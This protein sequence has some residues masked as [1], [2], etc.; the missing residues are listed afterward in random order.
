MMKFFLILFVTLCDIAFCEE[1]KD[2][3]T[4][5]LDGKP[6]KL[7]SIKNREDSPMREQP[8]PPAKPPEEKPCSR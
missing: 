7:S 1:V 8:A 5:I 6:V 4:V 3:P 2:D